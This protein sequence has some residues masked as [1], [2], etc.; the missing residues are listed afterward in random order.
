MFSGQTDDIAYIIKL[1]NMT[2]LVVIKSHKEKESAVLKLNIRLLTQSVVILVS[3]TSQLSPTL[4][5]PVKR[6][7]YPY[8][9]RLEFRSNAPTPEATK[10]K[11]SK[12]QEKKTCI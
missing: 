1:M 4:W 6:H 10:M 12:F 8:P 7:Q 5:V 11:I 2:P 9:L 3:C